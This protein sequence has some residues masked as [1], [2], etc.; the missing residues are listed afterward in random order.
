MKVKFLNPY[1]SDAMKI[2]RLQRRI[3]V[4]SFMYYEMNESCVSDG[5]YDLQSY[6]LLELMNKATPEDLEKTDYWYCMKDFDG[7]TGFDLFS[8]LT[9][10]DREVIE[11]TSRYVHKLWKSEK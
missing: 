3:L 7:N 11:R 8:R 6:Q 9:S 1:W 5:E 2:S 4:Y 10:R